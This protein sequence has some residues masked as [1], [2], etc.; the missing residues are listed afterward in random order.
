VAPPRAVILTGE[1]DAGKTTL[2]LALAALS[3][4][5]DGLVTPRLFDPAGNRAGIAARCLSTREEWVLARSD[6]DLD[7]PRFGRFGFS[8]AGIERAVG[9]L[10][11]ILLRSRG[12][13]EE[14][15][16]DR[17]GGKGSGDRVDRESGGDGPVRGTIV[18]I[19]EIGP[20]EL[21]QGTGLAPVLPLLAGAGHLLLV[22]RPSLA[23]LVEALVPG[24][25]R[26][27]IVVTPEHRTSLATAINVL[28]D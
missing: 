10:R 12:G 6:R 25:R 16:R 28:F 9:C 11:G 7:G 3:P 22:V 17:G 2:C 15:S 19:D 5:Y 8:S 20:L 4:R 18:V 26:T 21:E 13:G 24:H 23:G 1:R 14:G 27:V